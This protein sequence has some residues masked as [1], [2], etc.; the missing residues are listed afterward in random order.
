MNPLQ[1]PH[2]LR[3]QLRYRRELVPNEEALL[4]SARPILA[5][6]E[7]HAGE[8]DRFHERVLRSIALAATRLGLYED[9][10]RWRDRYIDAKE[11]KFSKVDERL[12][13]VEKLMRGDY[14][15]AF[16]DLENPWP[17]TEYY[18]AG[19]RGAR[20]AVL[21][22]DWDEADR[23]LRDAARFQ[24]ETPDPFPIPDGWKGE[25]GWYEARQRGILRANCELATLAHVAGREDLVLP[26][27]YR[28]RFVIEGGDQVSTRPLEETDTPNAWTEGHGQWALY[29]CHALAVTGRGPFAA[30]LA[31]PQRVE[32][33]RGDIALIYDHGT[34]SLCHALANGGAAKAALRMARTHQEEPFDSHFFL[35]HLS[36]DAFRW[37]NDWMGDLLAWDLL[38]LYELRFEN[39]RNFRY[40]DVERF[41]ERMQK[42][43]QSEWVERTARL[44][45]G[46]AMELGMPTWQDSGAALGRLIG[47]LPETEKTEAIAGLKQRFAQAQE[48]SAI[49]AALA[50]LGVAG[51]HLEQVESRLRTDFLQD[52]QKAD[53][54]DE[55]LI[56]LKASLKK[57][58]GRKNWRTRR[59]LLRYCMRFGIAEE[60]RS[61]IEDLSAGSQVD[62]L[63]DLHWYHANQAEI[64]FSK[65]FD[66]AR[67][68]PELEQRLAASAGVLKSVAG[69]L[70]LAEGP[71]HDDWFPNS[72]ILYDI[73][74][75]SYLLEGHS[76]GC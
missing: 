25:P 15:G 61:M 37:G 22:G 51:P 18:L 46:K 75:S 17:T 7:Q 54:A 38:A 71:Y 13:Y 69:R 19:F 14:A 6:L 50:V 23:L 39:P 55:A 56:L 34:T 9:A 8:V 10:D 32:Q 57:E 68:L 59:S 52:M 28:G 58:I 11:G 27:L 73:G 60:T 12:F 16:A 67:E 3:D 62:W 64:A 63:I 49:A 66:W 70:G 47:H 40:L 53:L 4:A 41:V 1:S 36:A 24:A 26:A 76:M 74:L 72:Q 2:P 65:A 44:V 33:W 5:F 31:T 43:G 20:F 35:M 48:G 42:A 29:F 45:V 30:E 21:N